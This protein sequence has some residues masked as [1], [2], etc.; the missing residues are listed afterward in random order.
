[1]H[2]GL[3]RG[4]GHAGWLA[5]ISVIWL[6]SLLHVL[7]TGIHTSPACSGCVERPRPAPHRRVST[8]LS[9]RRNHPQSQS[10]PTV[11][12][13]VHLVS[14]LHAIAEANAAASEGRHQD[15]MQ[16]LNRYLD[17]SDVSTGLHLEDGAGPL[18][19]R[20]S[21]KHVPAGESV[22]L[23][24]SVAVESP[25]H[26]RSGAVKSPVVSVILVALNAADTLEYA[27]RSILQQTWT[28]IE[29]IIVDDA[30][31]DDTWSLAQ[32]LREPDERVKLM[33]NPVRVG[34]YVSRNLAL[35]SATGTYVTC[36]D[37]DD[38]ALPHRLEVQ[39]RHFLDNAGVVRANYVYG[40]RVQPSGMVSTIAPPGPFSPD[41][42]ARRAYASAMYEARLLRKDLGYWDSV[43]Y[44]ADFEMMHRARA[45][46]GRKGFFEIAHVGVLLADRPNSLGKQGYERAP[47]DQ[48]ATHR[49]A[50]REAFGT[51]YLAAQRP[52]RP[53]Y[54]GFPLRGRPFPAPDAMVVGL[55]DVCACLERTPLGCAVGGD[56]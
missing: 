51:W 8:S 7:A 5:S 29:L 39:V 27:A 42:V 38:W 41:G 40:L 50:Y 53:L 21:A 4:M 22:G 28:A 2:A 45:F 52:N 16:H 23:R 33:R 19:G 37:A 3:I 13:N 32:A 30:S 49:E 9:M 11:P 18:L 12:R 55:V 26:R 24:R 46:L 10:Q 6:G 1:M 56:G 17:P 15:W 44:D 54:L 34:P 20:L 36:H 31:T 43:L 35:S 25:E 14:S 47:K 48:A